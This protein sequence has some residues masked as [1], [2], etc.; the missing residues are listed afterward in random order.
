MSK[1]LLIRLLGRYV[2]FV[3]HWIALPLSVLATNAYAKEPLECLIEPHRLI[4]VTS[5]EIGVLASVNVEEADVVVKGDTIA[6]LRTDV[7]H[8]ALD[9]SRARANANS[10]IELLRRDHDFAVRNRDRV[11]EL[12]DQE[13]VSAQAVDEVRTAQDAAWL[14]LQAAVERQKTAEL[15][16]AR[17]ELTLARR[18]VKSPIDGVV[19]SRYKSAGEYVDGDPIVQLAQLDPLRVRV[20]VPMTMFGEIQIG[21]QA[22]VLPELPIDGPFVAS[23]TSI[24]AM[25]DAATATLSVRLSLPNPD[26]RLPAGLKCTLVLHK[27]EQPIAA[28][29][30]P[31]ESKI[32][33]DLNAETNLLVEEAEEL[34]IAQTATTTVAEPVL[35]AAV[36]TASR[37]DG[38]IVD[39]ASVTIQTVNDDLIDPTQAL[40]EF[41]SA[42]NSCL[43]LGPLASEEAANSLESV[44]IDSDVRY[45]R[46]QASEESNEG[47]WSVLSEQP[48]EDPEG[49]LKFL[50]Q[51]EVKDFQWFKR[52]P[53]IHHMSY[54]RYS[55]LKN[56]QTRVKHMQS[57]GFEA[58]LVAKRSTKSTLWLDLP[59]AM[60]EDSHSELMSKLHEQIPELVNLPISCSKLAS[61]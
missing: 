23:V 2:I 31:D 8:A 30:S 21:M 1:S 11:N 46:R 34:T 50:E 29:V 56:A 45:V 52:G 17:D 28:L 19:A 35:A 47:P 57:L 25:M 43:S 6:A 18:I 60:S 58:Q 42:G 13:V 15:E 10:E 51:A 39:L 20:V 40:N 36:L 49:L 26:L 54:G 33:A 53:W 24:D 55:R 59:N 22:T 9:V 37:D 5:S 14:R 16:A 3:A 41:N 44:L 48:H 4:A 7:E 61:R 27:T 12:D 38:E 32:I